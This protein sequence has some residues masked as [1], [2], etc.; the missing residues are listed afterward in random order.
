MWGGGQDLAHDPNAQGKTSHQDLP[1]PMGVVNL[2]S[3]AT[4]QHLSIL[5]TRRETLKIREGLPEQVLVRGKKSTYKKGEYLTPQSFSEPW[6]AFFSKV[7]I[8]MVTAV[9]LAVN[10][11]PTLDKLPLAGRLSSCI[12]DWR[13]ICPSSWVCDVVEFGHKIPLK[14]IPTQFVIHS[15]P[16][17]V[18]NGGWS[19]WAEKERCCLLIILLGNIYRLI[20]LCLSH[21][22]QGSSG[23]S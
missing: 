8:M 16:P 3:L 22:P 1:A 13:K 10:M 14:Y 15:N 5:T 4:S 21:D 9:G 23:Q 19:K 6:L 17:V 12:Q 20:L 7:A 18:I 11:I 2:T